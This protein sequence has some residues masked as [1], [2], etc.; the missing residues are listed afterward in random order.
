MICDDLTIDEAIA[1]IIRMQND[2]EFG[3][4]LL[5]KHADEFEDAWL[6]HHGNSVNSFK[7]TL[8]NPLLPY[9]LHLMPLLIEWRLF[10]P[11]KI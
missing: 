4:E 5:R 6:D 8:N 1:L 7:W 2:R 11:P 10:G 3:D 9:R